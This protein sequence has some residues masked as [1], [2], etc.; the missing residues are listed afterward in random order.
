MHKMFIIS[1]CG[2]F[3]QHV[4]QEWKEF[5]VNAWLCL[6]VSTKT[7]GTTPH[8]DLLCLIVLFVNHMKPVIFF[9]M[10]YYYLII[11]RDIIRGNHM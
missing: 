1:C 3:Q 9:R 6:D 11:I 2:W 8:Y 7:Y 4:D 10:N 5:N